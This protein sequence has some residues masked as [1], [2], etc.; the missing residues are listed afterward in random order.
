MGMDAL[1]LAVLRL[2]ESSEQPEARRARLTRMRVKAV[3]LLIAFSVL[4]Y[5][6]F[7]GQGLAT[8]ESKLAWALFVGVFLFLLTG[9]IYYTNR[10]LQALEAASKSTDSPAS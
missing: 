7:R 9:R 5:L 4:G 3:I 2:E 10:R 6:R 8:T 1:K